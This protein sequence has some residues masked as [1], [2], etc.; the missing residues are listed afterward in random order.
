MSTP[1]QV[2]LDELQS[3]LPEIVHGLEE[4]DEVVIMGRKRSL[5]R[6]S[7]AVR[8][9][10]VRRAGRAVRQSETGGG[11]KDDTKYRV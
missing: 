2:S 9:S 11:I 5:P 7:I 6:A 4:G 3:K 1:I 8:R 10:S